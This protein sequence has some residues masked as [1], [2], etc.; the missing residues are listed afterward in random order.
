[1]YVR[2][3]RAKSASKDQFCL[4]HVHLNIYIMSSYKNAVTGQHNTEIHLNMPTFPFAFGQIL[5]SY[6]CESC[7]VTMD[8]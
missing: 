7:S 1:M 2:P 5:D 3:F 6:I 4:L 8:T